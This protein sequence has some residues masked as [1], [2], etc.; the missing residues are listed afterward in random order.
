MEAQVKGISEEER[1]KRQKNLNAARASV[2]V[3]GFVLNKEAEE[4]FSMYVN[5][6]ITRSQLNE[7]VL[8]NTMRP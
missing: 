4:L 8:K 5:G 3:E 2:R 7:A 1:Q 6:E